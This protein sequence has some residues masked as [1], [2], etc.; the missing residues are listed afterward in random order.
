MYIVH[1]YIQDEDFPQE[2]QDQVVSHLTTLS[3][4]ANQYGFS[5]VIARVLQGIRD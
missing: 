4:C 3:R 5:G 1:E 2:L